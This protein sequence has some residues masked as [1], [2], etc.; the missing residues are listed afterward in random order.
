[1]S[2]CCVDDDATNLAALA[3]LLRQWGVGQL[4]SCH[5]AAGT[6]QLATTTAA[7]DVLILDYQLGQ[8]QHGIQLYQQ[9]KQFWPAVPAILV[10]AAP[11]PDLPERAKQAGMI[12]L[13]KPIKAAALRASL[14]YLRLAKGR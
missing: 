7:P 6:L 5:D 1:L 12:F 13:A 3:A 14:N 10:S 8:H 11:E 2:I 9:L 4:L